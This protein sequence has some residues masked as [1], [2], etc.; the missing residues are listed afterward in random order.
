MLEEAI[1][2]YL[3]KGIKEIYGYTLNE[4]LELPID[5]VD[6]L[7]TIANEEGTK[8]ASTLNAIENEFKIKPS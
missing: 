3:N 6:L 1:R 2:T 8:K 7:T 5:I 4:F